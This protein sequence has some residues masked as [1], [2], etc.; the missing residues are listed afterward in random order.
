MANIVFPDPARADAQGLICVGGDLSPRCVLAA[1]RQGIFPYY[2]DTT[3]ILWWSPDPRAIFEMDGFHVSRRLART[4]RAGKYFVTFDQAF[5]DV[6]RRC[7][8]RSEGTWI[9]SE[10]MAA[11]TELHRLGHAHSTEVWQNGELVGGVY[12]LAIGGLFAGESMFTAYRDGSSIALAHLV[13]HLRQRGYTLFDVQYLNDHTARLGAI[14]IPR[15]QYLA[16]LKDALARDV[17]FA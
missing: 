16:R 3:P 14:E 12:G 15:R 4:L 2:D 13:E 8:D 5:D 10:M 6:I 17:T 7:A 11:Y 1:Y 9:T